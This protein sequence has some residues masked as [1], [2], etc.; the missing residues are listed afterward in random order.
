MNLRALLVLAGLCLAA[1]PSA[2]AK[3]H[4]PKSNNPNVKR[5]M[6]RAKKH[7]APRKSRKASRA[8]HGAKA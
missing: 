8:R 5:A 7:Q 2:D 3:A 6:R 4:N 1:L